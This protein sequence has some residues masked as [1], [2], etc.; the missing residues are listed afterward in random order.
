MPPFAF[1][2][3]RALAK[4]LPATIHPMILHF[5]IALLYIAVPLEFLA[6]R[7][8][9]EGFLPRAAFWTVTLSCVAIIVTMTAGFI[10]E[11]S[12]H[13]T[14]TT[15]VILERHQTLAILTGLCAGA[16]WLAHMAGRFPKGQRWGLWGRGQGGLI[17]ALFVL[18]AAVFVTLT[19]R[20]GGEMVYHYGVGVLGVTR[21]PPA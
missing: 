13:W 15:S 12:V 21:Q 17:S 11:Q 20:L 10:S 14:A 1:T 5:P 7:W 19:G 2:V 18:A 3:A 9:K 16:A 8:R 4:R 6:L